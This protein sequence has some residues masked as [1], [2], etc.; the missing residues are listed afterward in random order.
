MERWCEVGSGRH[1]R[2]AK[3]AAVGLL[4]EVSSRRA[5]VRWKARDG[6]NWCESLGGARRCVNLSSKTF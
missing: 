4:A 1:R 2:G 3:R 6:S 5:S